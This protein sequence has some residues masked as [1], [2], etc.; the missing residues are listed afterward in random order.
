MI[1]QNQYDP[2]RAQDLLWYLI[3]ELRRTMT[4]RASMEDQWIV[5]EEIYRARPAES[6]KN[7]PFMGASNLVVPVAATD[8]DTLYARMMGMLFD[9]P[10]LWAVTA[11]RPELID[12]AEA[13]TTFMAWAQE[14]EIKPYRAVGNWLI[15]L[16][17]LGTGIMKERYVREMKKVY[18]WREQADGQ[19]WQQ[20]AVILLKDHPELGHVRL[21]DFYIPAGFPLIQQA[22][23]VA[24]RVRLTWMQFMN[25]VKAG[26]YSGADQVGA[27]FFNPPLNQGQARMDTISGYKASV[28]Q[29]MEFYEFWLDFDIDNDGW[30]EALVCTVHLESQTYVRL[31]YN[32]FFNQEKPYTASNFMRDV[33]SFYGIGLCEMLDHFQEEITAMHNQRIDNG[34]VTNSAMYAIKSGNTNIRANEPTYPGKIW[35]LNDP[36]NDIVRMPLGDGGTIASSIENEQATRAEARSRTG[37]NDYI[38]GNNSPD[39]GY[40]AAYTTQQMLA[41]A[42]KRLG[43]TQR[44]IANGLGESGTRLLELYQQF[45]PRGKPF[46]ALGQRDGQLVDVILKMPL[47][48]I[49]KGLKVN[50]SAINVSNSK[51]AMIRTTTIVFQ[52]LQQYYM[53]YLQ[54]LSMAANPQ[55]PPVIQQVALHAA[56]GSSVLMKRLL[57]L[58]EIHDYDKMLPELQG[59]MNAQQQVQANI[60][61]VLQ[62]AQ[63]GQTPGPNVGPAGNAPG[64]QAPSGVAGFPPISPAGFGGGGLAGTQNPGQFGPGVQA[65]GAASPFGAGF[66][67]RR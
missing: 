4:D 6:T 9:N 48:L 66:A 33:N 10:G 37:V 61:A 40:G 42:S 22:P 2:K 26:L 35:R 15:E 8:V 41:N 38:Q 54:M 27:W 44:E 17:K 12:F 25:R 67:G 60:A 62:S 7:F 57:E 59:G 19:T 51:D 32:P 21:N 50:I 52:T 46:V 5:W 16:H 14:N 43:E 34:T 55:L 65:P 13:A 56:E 45:N 49:R 20:Q 11:Q 23:W 24:E 58:Y 28:N 47:D 39:I 31:D 53:N 18:E 63:L 30:D 36:K 29:Q 3:Q 1:P 64:S